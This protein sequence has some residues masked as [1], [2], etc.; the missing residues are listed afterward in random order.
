MEILSVLLQFTS[1]HHDDNTSHR[2]SHD[3]FPGNSFTTKKKGELEAGGEVYY[4]A[5]KKG[6][7]MMTWNRW[8]G[9][10]KKITSFSRDWRQLR[11]F[12]HFYRVIRPPFLLPTRQFTLR[13]PQYRY[14]PHGPPGWKEIAISSPHWRRV[15]PWNW[16][17]REKTW[18]LGDS[19]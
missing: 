15:N 16:I 9:F 10:R 2:P 3:I 6:G 5:E 4:L 1:I 8:L 7:H 18:Y 13:C 11:N 14:W 19:V 17:L 12:H